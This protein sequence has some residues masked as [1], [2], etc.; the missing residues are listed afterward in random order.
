MILRLLQMVPE[1]EIDER[2]W[3]G[4]LEKL[5]QG[6][7][8]EIVINT[9]YGRSGAGVLQNFARQLDLHL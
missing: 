8:Q 9:N 1:E 7:E 4:K 6:Q 2:E 5:K 3:W